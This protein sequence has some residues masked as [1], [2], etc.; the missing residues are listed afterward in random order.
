MK[1]FVAVLAAGAVLSG[2]GIA[3]AGQATARPPGTTTCGYG[4]GA[5]VCLTVDG[6]LASATGFAGPAGGPPQSAS[7]RLE[8]GTTAGASLEREDLGAV[9]PAGGITV[10]PVASTVPCGT[11]I[12]ATFTTTR[13]GRPPATATVT[14]PAVC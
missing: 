2:L 5:Q 1:R 4:V 8:L 12:T 14:V 13:A 3:G 7:F 10:G 11:G 6:R 9:V